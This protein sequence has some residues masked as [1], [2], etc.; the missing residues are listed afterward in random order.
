LDAPFRFK[1]LRGLHIEGIGIP[2]V[3][4][5]PRPL[6]YIGKG[7]AM[8]KDIIIVETVGVGQQEIEII[9][10]A[11]TVVV[12]LVP[13][14]GD[15][16]QASKAGI[17]EIADIFVINNAEGAGGMKLMRELS[18]AIDMRCTPSVGR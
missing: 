17:M 4:K 5:E 9:Y 2:P 18:S 7:G 13:G 16:I 10:H 6:Q 3:I 1:P 12:V 15:E 11:Q 14:I 8:G